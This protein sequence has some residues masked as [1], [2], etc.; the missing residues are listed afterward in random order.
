MIQGALIV[1]GV[2]TL[3]PPPAH[4]Y[5]DPGSGSMMVQLLLAG[6]AGV[7]VAIKLF[8]RRV[9]AY[10]ARSKDGTAEDQKPSA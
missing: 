7:L 4:A 9:V 5:L 1:L 3:F 6:L 10:F 8:W 2:G